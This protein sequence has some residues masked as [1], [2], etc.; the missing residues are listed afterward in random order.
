MTIKVKMDITQARDIVLTCGHELEP[1][2]YGSGDL[3]GKV[4]HRN[5]YVRRALIQLALDMVRA[6]AEEAL[7]ALA[8]EA[9]PQARNQG[10]QLVR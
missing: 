2:F 9:E 10:V 3:L 1:T 7:E 5:D 8:A 6:R 4:Q